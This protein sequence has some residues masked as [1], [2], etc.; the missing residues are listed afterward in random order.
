VHPE[1]QQAEERR[2]QQDRGVDC[3]KRTELNQRNRSKVD[4]DG[5]QKEPELKVA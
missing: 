5:K 2:E 4:P 3:A 1:Y